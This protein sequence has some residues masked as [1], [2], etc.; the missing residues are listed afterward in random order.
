MEVLKV[1]KVTTS[2]IA[3]TFGFVYNIIDQYCI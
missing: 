3:M 1:L 2:I